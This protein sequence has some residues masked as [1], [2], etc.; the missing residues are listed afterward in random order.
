MAK[1]HLEDTYPQVPRVFG[2]EGARLQIPRLAHLNESK[3][4]SPE[5]E[6]LNMMK[7]WETR[8]SPTY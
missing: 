6:V 3:I 2:C 5:A 7:E 8:L 1:A 4:S